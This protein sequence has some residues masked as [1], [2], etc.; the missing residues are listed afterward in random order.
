MLFMQSSFVTCEIQKSA[1][2][3]FLLWAGMQETEDQELEE[4]KEQRTDFT[5]YKRRLHKK[6][7]ISY[8]VHLADHHE[9][10]IMRKYS[11]HCYSPRRKEE[12][13]KIQQADQPYKDCSLMRIS[14]ILIRTD[15][16]RCL[17]IMM[18]TP[19]AAMQWDQSPN[20]KV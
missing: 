5:G 20:E 6:H 15:S 18:H 2:R 13:S 7:S 19:S 11:N 8:P 10:D 12:F 1:R 3:F 17:N 14:S 9:E 4:T 16:V